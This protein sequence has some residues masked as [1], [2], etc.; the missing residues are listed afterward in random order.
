MVI[1]QFSQQKFYALLKQFLGLWLIPIVL[2][3]PLGGS[4]NNTK[5]HFPL[6]PDINARYPYRLPDWFWDSPQNAHLLTPQEVI[7][8]RK[9]IARMQAM[10][11]A[12]DKQNLETNIAEWLATK[13]SI[14]DLS[15]GSSVINSP[16][17]PVSLAVLIDPSFDPAAKKLLENAVLRFLEV[18]FDP[19]TIKKAY[20]RSTQRPS[21]MPEVYESK[22]GE[23]VVDDLQRPIYSENYA[24]YL[25]QRTKPVSTEAF[26]TQLRN[27]L[28]TPSG[29]RA[30]LMISRYSGDEWWGGGYNSF[31]A[32]P[33]Q[34]L[35]REVPSSGYLYI[36]LNSDKL[37][38]PQPE[39]NDINFWASKIA[40]ELLHNLG[41]WHP[42]YQ[43]PSERD[44]NNHE[45]AW[46]FVVSYEYAVLEKLKEPAV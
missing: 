20:D 4:A 10:T 42:N 18:A 8:T 3:L 34:Q 41:Y 1:M 40:H 39:W 15:S 35:K 21:P 29:D 19:Q 17:T 26:L 37:T 16:K 23:A 46:S 30:V 28:T 43:S 13:F 31:H 36:R 25:K 32:S 5:Q 45:N 2:L 11:S 27:A 22:D 38:Q 7:T 12:T 9:D 33:L 14:R 44:A 6:L 24:L